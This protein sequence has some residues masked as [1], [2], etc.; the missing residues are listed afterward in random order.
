MQSSH[1]MIASRDMWL[2]FVTNE[3][4]RVGKSYSVKY[5]RVNAVKPCIE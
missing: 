5:P 3:T 4:E 2:G 1:R